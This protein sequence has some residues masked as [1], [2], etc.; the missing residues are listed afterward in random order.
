METAMSDMEVVSAVQAALADRVG[1][2][3]YECWFAHN[4]QLKLVD[5][6]LCVR[7]ASPFFQN[8]LQTHFREPLESACHAVLGRAVA[9][10]FVT[11]SDTAAC[12]LHIPAQD[13]RPLGTLQTG[14]QPGHTR[15]TSAP[16]CERA[17]AAPGASPRL[18]TSVASEQ[19]AT[20]PDQAVT[21]SA[22]CTIVPCVQ[23][24]HA[25]QPRIG[26]GGLMLIS[27]LPLCTPSGQADRAPTD[28]RAAE[29][30]CA[31]ASGRR[32]DG[33][34]AADGG[35]AGSSRPSVAQGEGPTKKRLASLW[36]FVAGP[37]NA[38]AHAAALSV[39]QCPGRTSP[40]VFYGP[41]SVGKTH[42]LEG[43]LAAV[44]GQHPATKALYLT[45]E[46]FTTAF[47]DALHGSGLPSFRRKLRDLDLFLLD[48][49]QFLAGKRAT[50]V[51]FIHTLD[52][53]HRGGKQVVLA[54]DRPPTELRALGQE[55][56][57]RLQA[58]LCVAVNLPVGST[59]TLLVRKL[60]ARL[61]I[62]A[63]EDVL[64]HV[65]QRVPSHA[66]ALLGALRRLEITARAEGRPI[67]LDLTE[68]ALADMVHQQARAIRL[69]DI[70]QAVC[71]VCGVTQAELHSESRSRH[72]AD[73]RA[74]AMWLARKYTRAALAEIGQ[75]FGRKSHTSVLGAKEKVDTWLKRQ[76]QMATRAGHCSVAEAIRQVEQRLMAG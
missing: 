64:E 31:P 41:T 44:R 33:S 27:R 67:T 34:R 72:V 21:A 19:L 5:E 12:S 46:Q 48:D 22:A 60:A 13:V 63:G 9:V 50:L 32:T 37:E 59:R 4:T 54:A 45:A 36:D 71:Q 47:L 18:A 55:L 75:Y 53:L 26:E 40:L 2:E 42:L 70:E 74:L 49:L 62:E 76:A 8:W 7:V 11:E 35:L 52:T 14:S 20:N 15:D 58:G 66:R 38:V 17:C 16:L 1:H 3:R 65:A 56:V 51:E 57:T 73:P 30:R 25:R 6:T 43:L 28:G 61:G 23:D 29:G 68:R 39:V 24:D 69:A 10:V